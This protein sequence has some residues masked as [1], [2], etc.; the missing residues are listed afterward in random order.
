MF[1]PCSAEELFNLLLVAVRDFPSRYSCAVWPRLASIQVIQR[2]AMAT[3]HSPCP[4]ELTN[5][6]Q[7]FGPKFKSQALSRPLLP[8]L[9]SFLCTLCLPPTDTAATARYHCTSSRSLSN[10]YLDMQIK[11]STIV[12]AQ[13]PW[14][15]RRKNCNNTNN[16]TGQE[17]HLSRG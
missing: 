17:E 7:L 2:R 8:L 6:L 3:L 15:S 9:S 1:P 16:N 12:F 11:N 14:P 13:I 10:S 5:I 4:V